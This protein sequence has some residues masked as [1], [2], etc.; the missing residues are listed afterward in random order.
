MNDAWALALLGIAIGALPGIFALVQNRKLRK[1]QVKREEAET[2]RAHTAMTLLLSQAA[3]NLISSLSEEVGRQNI[4]IDELE[5]QM[6]SNK[7]AMTMQQVE[8]V[9]LREMLDKA[10]NRIDVLEAENC[11]LREDNHRLRVVLDRL[12]T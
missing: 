12:D 7:E 5:A 3:T 9:T 11:Q 1:A 10:L 2:G 6:Y 8:M 4:R